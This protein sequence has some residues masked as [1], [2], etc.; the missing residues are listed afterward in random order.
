[1]STWQTRTGITFGGLS[2][3]AVV[4]ALASST[5]SQRAQSLGLTVV[6]EAG[7]NESEHQELHELGF[8]LAQGFLYGRPAIDPTL[9]ADVPLQRSNGVMHA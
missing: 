5:G 1:M 7:E 9:S 2:V 8:D 6:A 3:L 4:A